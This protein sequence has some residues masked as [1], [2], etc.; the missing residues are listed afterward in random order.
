ML[1]AI[2]RSSGCCLSVALNIYARKLNLSTKNTRVWVGNWVGCFAR[3]LTFWFLP[4]RS[5]LFPVPERLSFTNAGPPQLRVTEVSGCSSG[6]LKLGTIMD[7]RK[8]TSCTMSRFK[9]QANFPRP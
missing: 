2:G 8:L 4:R 6:R 1:P 3:T 5:N 7:R 9:R